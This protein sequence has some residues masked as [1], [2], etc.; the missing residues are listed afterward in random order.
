MRIFYFI[1][2]LAITTTLA[3]LLSISLQLKPGV[4][5]P[6][7]GSFFCPFTG[8]WQNA[9]SQKLNLQ[10]KLHLKGIDKSIEIKID[11]RMVPHITA[12]NQHDLI[13]AQGYITAANR[14]WEMDIASRSASGRL[15]EVIGTKTINV[16]KRTRRRGLMLAAENATKV[17]LTNK[18]V[19][20][21]MNAYTDGVNA[22]IDQLSAKEYPIEF[23]LL[24]YKPEK[25]TPLKIA[26]LVSSMAQTLSSKEYDL[27]YTNSLKLFGQEDFDKL[28][29]EQNPNQTPIIPAG[30]K[31]DYIKGLPAVSNEVKQA[32]F[33]D[34]F[35]FPGEVSDDPHIGSNNWVV[36]PGKTADKV[37]ILCNDPHLNLTLPSIWFE[38]QLTAPG[39]NSYGASL[40]GAPGIIIGFNENIAWGVTN[41]EWDVLDWYKINWADGSKKA[42]I[43]DGKKQDVTY[44]IEKIMVKDSIDYIDTVKYTS[45]GPVV[46]EDPKDPAYG[47]AMRWLLHNTSSPE[48]LETFLNLNSA[49]SF[50]DYYSATNKYLKPAQNIIF[51][52]NNGDIALRILGRMPL[53]TKGDGKFVMDGSLSSNG[54]K[55][56]VP[57][58]NNPIAK[59]PAQGYLTS[60]NQN[61]TATDYPFYYLGNYDDFRGRYIN[62]RLSSMD[63]VTIEDMM[64][65]QNDPYSIF[66][67]EGLPALLGI[68]DTNRLN[69]EE[70]E[71][72]DSLKKWKYIFRAENKEPTCFALWWDEFRKQTWDEMFSIID[73]IPVMVPENWRT[74]ELLKTQ[75]N[76]KYFDKKDTE[77][78]ETAQDIVLSSF[79]EMVSQFKLFASNPAN[80]NGKWYAYRN[81]TIEHI[82]RIPAFSSKRVMSDGFKD[83][84]NATTTKTGPSWR[85]IVELS[86]PIKAWGI[87]PG[88]QSGNPGSKYYDNMVEKWSKGQYDE[89]VFLTKENNDSDRIISTI[90]ITK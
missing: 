7:L 10:T 61:T 11:D 79:R 71:M 18:N 17:W 36:G 3:Y 26:L 89:L 6:P 82:G 16:D 34:L 44:R 55:T 1:L 27:E 53:R 72:Y 4:S 65:L 69:D 59:N 38:I 14:L 88:G 68:L 76:F 43:L 5:L 87:Y 30:T 67:E 15:S 66:A 49:T 77:K 25:W 50:D 37:P 58:E 73:S 86:K 63:S 54:W 12:Q 42:Y 9:E 81:T 8:F 78:R 29:P 84:I 33:G 47:L 2:S 52:S 19:A 74:I 20:E 80:D 21:I 22:Y 62:R 57:N 31:W 48:E 56:T 60:S 75:P 32:V 64:R 28:Y 39:I 41:A 46:Y 23:K 90:T 45:W 51:A 70:R 13:F 40:P 35:P 83:A 24:D 85:M